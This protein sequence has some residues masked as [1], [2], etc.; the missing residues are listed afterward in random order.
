MCAAHVTHSLKVFKVDHPAW[1]ICSQ[2]DNR[3]RYKAVVINHVRKNKTE[4]EKKNEKKKLQ[5]G[6]RRELLSKWM[7]ENVGKNTLT[8]VNFKILI[9]KQEDVGT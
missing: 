1:I 6:T 4:D 7:K 5:P 9:A 2:G 3:I 8:H